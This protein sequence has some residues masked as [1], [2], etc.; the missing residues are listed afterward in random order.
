MVNKRKKLQD[1]TIK[2]NF[3]FAA[4]M[5]EG[6]N[7]KKLLELTLDIEIDH[8]DVYYEKS[9]VYNPEY[10]GVRLDVEDVPEALVKFLKYVAAGPELSN[11]DYDDGFIKQLQNSVEKIK[12]SRDMEGRYMLLEEMMKNE[13]K[14][15]RE[16][17]IIETYIDSILQILKARFSVSDELSERIRAIEDKDVLSALIL[18]AVLK[19]SVE[20]F[21]SEL[22]KLVSDQVVSTNIN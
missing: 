16:D 17:G 14:A 20:E 6:D 18:S 22:N 11:I 21:E 7:A 4:V 5:L 12:K 8:V 10:K 13:Y 3:M 2:D 1:L 19:S 15:G 9:I